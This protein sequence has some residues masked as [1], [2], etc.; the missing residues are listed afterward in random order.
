MKTV[1]QLAQELGVT[2]QTIRNELKR[3]NLLQ[4]DSKSK[5]AILIDENAEILIKSARESRSKTKEQAKQNQNTQNFDNDLIAFFKAQLEEKD[6]QIA[7]LQ[8]AL[9]REQAL[10]RDTQLKL[11]QHDSRKWWQFWRRSDG[12]EPTESK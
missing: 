6:K 5:S 1:K 11:E 2:E 10:H 4:K 12:S 7:E 8:A 9:Y 3:Q